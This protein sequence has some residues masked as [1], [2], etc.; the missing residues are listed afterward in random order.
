M[1]WMVIAGAALWL[2]LLC[3]AASG[4][5]PETLDGRAT[6]VPLSTAEWRQLYYEIQ[7]G[8]P[9]RPV[10]QDL[11]AVLALARELACDG[12]I[13]LA[14]MN[15]EVKPDRRTESGDG[16]QEGTVFAVAP[17][18]AYTHRG[19]EVVFNLDHRLY[20]TNDPR[21]VDR[22]E[23]D[24]GDGR[25]FRDVGLDGRYGVSYICTGPKEIRVR[26]LLDDGTVLDG[27]ANFQVERLQTPAPHDTLSIAAT[28]AYGGEYGTGE[29]YVYLSDSHTTLMDPVVVIEGFDID[30]SMD[31]EELYHLLNQQGLVDTLRG[32]G[33]DA[34]V[35]NFTDATDYI[36]RNAFVVTELIEQ[37]KVIVGPE[38]DLAVVGASMGGLAGRYALAYMEASS[39]DHNVR[40]FISF[41]SPQDGANIPLG[42]QYWVKFFSSQSADAALMLAGLDSPAAK[43]MLVYHYT[44]PPGA[45][46]ESDP[47][48]DDL[49]SDFVALGGYPDNPRLV[50]VANGSGSG[51]SQGFAPGD[52]LILYEYES[53]L[54]DIVGN[55]WA[56]P[57]GS[58]HI[59]FDGLIDMIWPLPDEEMTVYVSGTSPY[60][61][62]PG[63]WR[64]SMAQMDSTVAPYGDIIALH[65]NHCFIPTV[66]ALDLDTGDLFYDIAGDLDLMSK[67]P[68]DTVYY[69]TA[70]QE[71]VLITEENA[72][73]FVSEIGRDALAS[74]RP[75]GRSTP[76]IV[77]EQNRP[78]PFA[79][80]TTIRFGAAAGQHVR[81]EIFNV[82]G[83]LVARLFDSA[84]ARGTGEV[85]WDG[86]DRHGVK[87][88]PGLYLCRLTAAG[89]TR[90]RYL[91]LLR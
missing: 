79:Y 42:L 68:F 14:I 87:V 16:G 90:V 49:V 80:A 10:E 48:R 21:A 47:L 45:D 89:M 46:G 50:A 52:Q 9:V 77:L 25:G 18:K 81:L 60:D 91:V 71:H 83:Q 40:T 43:Q 12:S 64:G 36:Q 86:K 54:V 33:F 19:Q 26:L 34:V 4:S 75:P 31:W 38:T 56:V 30:N 78:N 65:D 58:S 29:A 23:V 24:F 1:R 37:I 67:T 84:V 88:A 85:V 70:N 51:L 76:G 74:I 5:G 13:Q 3:P 6:A 15:L 61:G 59:I 32:R 20:L 28:I 8:S 44:D 11:D 27:A 7:R 17:M 66:S 53:F 73:W 35:L 82:N 39:V 2:W 22:L 57:D 72:G 41:D 63:G 62:A 69:P 55:V